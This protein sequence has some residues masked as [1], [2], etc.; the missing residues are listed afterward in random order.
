MEPELIKPWLDI[1]IAAVTLI[2]LVLGALW[3]Y[4]KFILER[5]YL[6]PVEFKVGCNVLGKQGNK[7]IVEVLLYLKNLGNSTLV[8]TDIQ[9][10]VRYVDSS[11]E[12]TVMTDVAKATFAHMCFPHVFSKSILGEQRDSPSVIPIVPHDTFVQPGVNQVYTLVTALPQSATYM[13]VWAQFRYAQ[14]PSRLQWFVIKLS[15]R[16]G[17]IHYSLDHV[18]KPHTTERAFKLTCEDEAKAAPL[19]STSDS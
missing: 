19:V 11:E 2:G 5:G 13:L 1:V 15:R 4:T 8:A 10:R 18:T 12:V 3:A 14:H 9:T 16:L 6:P 7:H 17:L